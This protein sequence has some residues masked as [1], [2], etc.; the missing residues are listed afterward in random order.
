[1]YIYIHMYV[2][3]YVCIYVCI[4]IYVCVYAYIYMLT[5]VYIYIYICTYV[6]THI[7]TYVR[8]YITYSRTNARTPKYAP[9]NTYLCFQ[10]QKS[11]DQTCPAP[12]LQSIK[13]LKREQRRKV[14]KRPTDIRQIQSIETE[15]TTQ[16]NAKTHL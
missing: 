1:M 6:F 5:Y 9:P 4:Y 16:S 12:H 10:S 11:A 8:I 14:L 2:Y 15:S 7:H 3:M 13:Y